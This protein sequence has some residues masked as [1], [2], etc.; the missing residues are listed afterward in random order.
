MLFWYFFQRIFFLAG[1]GKE[2]GGRIGAIIDAA[3]TNRFRKE[4]YEVFLV[5]QADRY[6]QRRPAP[7]LFLSK[8]AGCPGP[9]E[10]SG[11]SVAALPI[12]QGWLTEDH[13]RSL[14][15]EEAGLFSTFLHD[16]GAGNRCP[17]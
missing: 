10:Q 3:T 13:G 2:I 16:R 9:R 12:V 1:R 4:K 5:N 6:P 17:F 7:F 14:L 15:W 8:S 11:A